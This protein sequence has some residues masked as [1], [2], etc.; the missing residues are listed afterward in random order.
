MHDDDRSWIWWEF[1][2][3]DGEKWHSFH[4]DDSYR[5]SLES[6]S[7]DEEDAKRREKVVK[8]IYGA[9]KEAADNIKL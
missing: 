9:F 4:L 1:G 3:F 2:L 8:T 7:V 5:I 6:G